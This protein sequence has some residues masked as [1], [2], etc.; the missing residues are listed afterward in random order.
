MTSRIWFF[1]I[2]MLIIGCAAS[3]KN[4]KNQTVLRELGSCLSELRNAPEPSEPMASPCG[5]R[6]DI[7][8]LVGTRKTDIVDALGPP[9]YHGDDG[10]TYSFIRFPANGMWVGGGA[11]LILEF[12]ADERCDS[13]EWLFSR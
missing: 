8:A 11:T 13:A 9:N 1:S 3:S 12:D 10:S 4:I 5:G 7:A 6:G 2:G